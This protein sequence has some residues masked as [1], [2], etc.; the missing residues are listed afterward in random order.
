MPGVAIPLIILST[1]TISVRMWSRI[2][3]QTGSFGLDDVLIFLSYV[4]YSEMH[5]CAQLIF[6]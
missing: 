5:V 2:T 3:R 1:F 6:F 4:R